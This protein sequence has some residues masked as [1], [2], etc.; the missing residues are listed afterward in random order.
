[1]WLH[2]SLAHAISSME[3]RA[4]GRVGTRLRPIHPEPK[5]QSQVMRVVSKGGNAVRKFLRAGVPVADAA[6]PTRVNMKHLKPELRRIFN[7][8]MSFFFVD[9]HPA[10]PTIVHQ[11]RVRGI[12]QVGRIE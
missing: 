10:S 9:F 3:V 8:A 6:E 2:R 4:G 5:L 11:E 1:M 7:H 12:C